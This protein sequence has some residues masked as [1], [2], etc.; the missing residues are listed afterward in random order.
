MSKTKIPRKLYGD[1]GLIVSWTEAEYLLDQDQ[2]QYQEG[3]PEIRDCRISKSTKIGIGII[4]MVQL[5]MDL[6]PGSPYMQISMPFT[7]VFSNHA[8]S[9]GAGPCYVNDEMAHTFAKT[10]WWITNQFYPPEIHFLPKPKKPPDGIVSSI[11]F[12]CLITAWYL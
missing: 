8:S 2:Y 7:Q 5:R 12:G 4:G 9:F 6:H 10:L 3:S 11:I 1:L